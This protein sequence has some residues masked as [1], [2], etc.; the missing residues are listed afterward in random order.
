MFSWIY[1]ALLAT[2]SMWRT[3]NSL[4]QTSLLC[5]FENRGVVAWPWFQTPVAA[6]LLCCHWPSIMI[7]L[8]SHW[9]CRGN[10]VSEEPSHQDSAHWS[11]HPIRSNKR[12]MKGK[13]LKQ[14]YSSSAALRAF[15]VL[16]VLK[17]KC[18]TLTISQTTYIK[19]IWCWSRLKR[20][21]QQICI[22]KFLR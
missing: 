7:W 9:G 17:Y 16:N 19:G 6:S 5:P 3:D 8:L 1:F 21:L 11:G 4:S 15:H 14:D 2:N 10:V 12:Q 18:R 20:P 13:D 22:K